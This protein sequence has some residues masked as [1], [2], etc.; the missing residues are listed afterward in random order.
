MLALGIHLSFVPT[1]LILTFGVGAGAATPT[2]GGLGGFEA[3]L[4]GGFV[5]YDVN[6]SAALAIALLYRLISYWLTLLIGAGAF[7]FCQRQKWLNF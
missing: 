1:L 2:P 3:G 4:V 7:I 5:A 6:A